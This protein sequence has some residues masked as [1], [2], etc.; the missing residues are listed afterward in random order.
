MIFGPAGPDVARVVVVMSDGS[1]LR[2]STVAAGGQRYFAVAAR[3]TGI[4]GLRWIGY[5]STRRQV[6]TG[7]V[8]KPSG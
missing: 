6:A 3:R 7:L 5:D 2:V 4:R 1:R 8:R